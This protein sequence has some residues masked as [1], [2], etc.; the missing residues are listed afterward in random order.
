MTSRIEA[1]SDDF[2]LPEERARQL[3]AF[4]A[5]HPNLARAEEGIRRE[6]GL[7]P[8]RYVVLLHRLID[9]QQALDIDPIL[10]HRL[11]R[12]RDA[13]IAEQTRRLGHLTTH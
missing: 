8:A 3:L 5:T 13:G 11:R 12:T 6:L 9:T 4:A 7:T 2:G 10:T 1:H